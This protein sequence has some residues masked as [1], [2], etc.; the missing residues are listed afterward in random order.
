MRRVIEAVLLLGVIFPLAVQSQDKSAE[1]LVRQYLQARSQTMQESA[2]SRD[3]DTALSFCTEG[4]V[5]EHPSVGARIEGK[6]KSRLGMSGYLGQTKDPT[7]KIQILASNPHVVVARVDQQ[8]FVKQE[9]GS[10]NPGKRSNITVF[11]IE[12]GKINRILDY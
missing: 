10:W 7:Y 12:G 1:R 3:I 4:F 11:E 8:F 6:E 2:T 5:Y 9:E